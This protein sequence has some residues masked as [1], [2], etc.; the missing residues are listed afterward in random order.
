MIS[1]PIELIDKILNYVL[2]DLLD[3][4]AYFGS[5]PLNI[6]EHFRTLYSTCKTFNH[7]L[8]NS[9]P[10]L[11]LGGYRDLIRNREP[12]PRYFYVPPFRA[13]TAESEKESP[14]SIT[15]SWPKVF[16]RFQCFHVNNV[17][18]NFQHK[19]TKYYKQ[20]GKFWLNPSLKIADLNDLF[21]CKNGCGV[22]R[23]TLLL[24]LEH[25]HVRQLD[26]D[27]W[28]QPVEGNWQ[29]ELAFNRR[30]YEF[31]WEGLENAD[32]PEIKNVRGSMYGDPQVVAVREWK[33]R[34][35][36]QFSGANIAPEVK[37]WWVWRETKY[38]HYKTWVAGYHEGKA[39]VFDLM[40]SYLFTNFEPSEKIAGCGDWEK[41]QASYQKYWQC[42]YSGPGKGVLPNHGHLK[43]YKGL[44][45]DAL[46]RVTTVDFRL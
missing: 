35:D 3:Q 16:L 14:R 2:R 44:G 42:E 20:L 19:T 33:A 37:V 7:C 17:Y 13:A 21:R 26:E 31:W 41:G 39:W 43:L 15:T 32:D 30:Q 4:M 10:K 9:R 27:L 36:H 1:L 22:N 40:I 45:P 11:H 5:L 24:L 34:Y 12:P 46:T 28:N 29:V 38:K 25:L 18:H 23:A 6:L 8:E